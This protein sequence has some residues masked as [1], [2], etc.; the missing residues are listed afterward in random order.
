MIVEPDF[1]DHWKT[2]L[3]VRLLGTETAPIH[4][5]RL[6]AHCQSRK[7]DRF[8][9]WKPTVLASVC[10]WDGDAQI[11]WD[12]MVQTYCFLDGDV[13]VVHDWAEVNRSLIS[14]WNNGKNGGRPPSKKPTGNRP[15]IPQETD[16]LSDREDREDREEKNNITGT[17]AANAVRPRFQKPTFDQ[18]MEEAAR[19]GL[20][21]IECRKF[22]SYYESNGWKVGKGKMKCWKSSLNGWKLRWE[23]GIRKFQQHSLIGTSTP[24]DAAF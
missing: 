18:I 2:R 9:G 22:E 15:V 21:E 8:T 5:I 20:P 19:M 4:V 3:L 14:A 17:E 16:W 24:D 1:L 13:L 6:W 11:F 7:T 23:D 12:S 10:R